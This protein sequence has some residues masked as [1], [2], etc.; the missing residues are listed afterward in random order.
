MRTQLIALTAV[1]ILAAASPAVARDEAP[2]GGAWTEC[3]VSSITAYRDRL[4]VKCSGMAGG[5][6][7]REFAVELVDRMAELVLRLSI[8][9]KGR[10]RPLNVLY[11][12]SASANPA[13]CAA[14]GCR[15]VAG[16]ELK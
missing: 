3:Q 13:G 15:R 10:A 11:V 4:V 9:A 1:A 6:A 12:K 16:V 14:E 8:E 7:P 5:E 2:E